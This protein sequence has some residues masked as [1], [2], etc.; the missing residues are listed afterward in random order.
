MRRRWI[1]AAVAALVL[2]GPGAPAAAGPTVGDVIVTEA[3]DRLAP[4]SCTIRNTGAGWFIL[5]TSGHT[6]SNCH[7]V[8][9]AADHIEVYY[10]FTAAAVGSL[11]VDPDESLVPY[12][13]AG[14]SVGLDHVNIFMFTAIG[15]TR[16]DPATVHSASGNW[17]IQGVMRL[18]PA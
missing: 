17:W 13:R 16:L 8:V 9:Q 4:I 18:G 3:G 1:L 6:P 11:I 14:G 12:Y 10:G 5:D 7:H 2:L 15:A